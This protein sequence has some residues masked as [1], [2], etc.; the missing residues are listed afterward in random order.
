MHTE[1][2]VVVVVKTYVSLKKAIDSRTV[3]KTILS[4]GMVA[5]VLR[6]GFTT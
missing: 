3:S 1:C 5:A 4:L 6:F 2:L